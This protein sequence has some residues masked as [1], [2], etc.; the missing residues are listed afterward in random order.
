MKIRE[1]EKIRNGKREKAN[2]RRNADKREINVRIKGNH[3]D[4]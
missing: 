4:A 1:K 3:E 2:Q